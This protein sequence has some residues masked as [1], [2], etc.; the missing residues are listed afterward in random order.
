M[1]NER[2]QNH[3]CSTLYLNTRW[4]DLLTPKEVVSKREMY[5]C[6]KGFGHNYIMLIQYN[7]HKRLGIDEINMGIE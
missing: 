3:S 1:Q 7:M 5:G 6:V 2:L 4:S